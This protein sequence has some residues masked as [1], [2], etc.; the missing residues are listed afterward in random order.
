LWSLDEPLKKNKNIAKKPIDKM[1][2]NAKD[3]WLI[4]KKGGKEKK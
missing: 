2:W 1:K 3:T 4:P